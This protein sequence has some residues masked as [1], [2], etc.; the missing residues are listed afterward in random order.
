[1]YKNVLLTEK[2][3]KILESIITKNLTN[4]PKEEAVNLTI[5]LNQLKRSRTN[6]KQFISTN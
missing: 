3:I 6:Q 1:M 4:Y 2:E 5:L